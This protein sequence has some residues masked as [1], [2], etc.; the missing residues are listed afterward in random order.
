MHM[1]LRK[2]PALKII[3]GSRYMK[4]NS[5]LNSNIRELLPPDV[6]KI[7]H[8]VPI[9]CVYRVH[10]IILKGMIFLL[11]MKRNKSNEIIFIPKK[12]QWLTD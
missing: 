6:N 5:C 7:M 1:K 10:K 11:V 12:G 9:P 8:P 3:G 2:Y 4:K